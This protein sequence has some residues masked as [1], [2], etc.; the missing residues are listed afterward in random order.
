MSK[1]PST[2]SPTLTSRRV[3]PPPKVLRPKPSATRPA[4]ESTKPGP[5]NGVAGVC[6]AFGTRTSASTM[7]AMPIGPL[8]RKS[9]RQSKK[10]AT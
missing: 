6:D 4:E 5:S 7:P 8:I 2:A 3:V 9:K 10:V 1:A